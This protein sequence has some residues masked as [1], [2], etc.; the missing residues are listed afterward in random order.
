[1]DFNDQLSLEHLLF[2][3]RKCRTCKKTKDLIEGYYLT[4]RDR[5]EFPSSYSYECKECTIRRILKSRKSDIERW[6][7]PDW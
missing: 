6:E 2:K 1:M 3:E 4:R 5:G 7:Y